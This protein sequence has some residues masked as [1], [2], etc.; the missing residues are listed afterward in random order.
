MEI[1]KRIQQLR[2]LKNLTQ[3]YVADQ[4]KMNQG[5]YS[6]LES[7]E[8]DITYR[9]LEQIAEI[10]DLR[11]EDVIGFNESIVFN[12]INNKS[13]NGLVINQVSKNEKRL[14]EEYIEA[15]KSEN[16][17]LKTL[18]NKQKKKPTKKRKT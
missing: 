6:K 8:T 4:L 15:L 3:T 2:E 10:L 1:G 14:Y 11:P 5:S 16:K 13:A 9:R 12:L 17:F 7:G 18:V